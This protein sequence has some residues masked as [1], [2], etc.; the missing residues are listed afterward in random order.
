M[1]TSARSPSGPADHRLL[2]TSDG[3]HLEAFGPIEWGL[4][5]AVALI[6]GSSFALIDVG[7]ESFT[8]GTV[9][10]ARV[11]LGALA[12][13][14]LPRSRRPVARGDLP[15]I[16]LLG[17]LWLGIPMILF[18]VAQQWIDS[19]VAG[20]LNAAVPLSTAAWAAVLTRRWPRRGPTV[21]LLLGA[22]GIVAIGLPELPTGVAADGA[23]GATAL[24]VGL[25]L[26]AMLMYGLSFNLAVPL[27]QRYGPLSVLL[28]AQ[29][30]A[31]VVI[32]P[33]ALM[34][35]GGNT[36]SWR[37]A[38]AMLPLG[39]LGT[40]LAF[41][42]TTQLV[43]RVGGPRGSIAIYFT[44]VVAIGLGIVWLGEDLHPLAALGAA[45]VVGGAAITSR[46]V[47]PTGATDPPAV[48]P[49][50]AARGGPPHA[51]AE[52]PSDPG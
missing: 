24:G 3:T 50:G 44:P 20:M 11:G 42:L 36:W 15:T 45:L 38:A 5:A 19:S 31:L 4:L 17:V 23:T 7:L 9:A 49:G 32:A 43:G 16:A 8:P 22:A 14:V 1:S 40:G 34:T 30:A 39:V 25:V 51:A 2:R 6:W 48:G 37:S 47:A 29:L 13:A 41:V 28:R 10:L 18:P 12:L 26:L 33:Y 35:A 46:R 52:R 27:Q 21:G